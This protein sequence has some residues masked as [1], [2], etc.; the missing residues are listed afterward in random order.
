MSQFALVQ[1][2]VGNKTRK[3]NDVWV[4]ITEVPPQSTLSSYSAQCCPRPVCFAATSADM[5]QVL[6]S[7]SYCWNVEYFRKEYFGVV[8]NTRIKWTSWPAATPQD[9][10][11][12][13][14]FVQTLG[15]KG[16]STSHGTTMPNSSVSYARVNWF[17]DQQDCPHRLLLHVFLMGH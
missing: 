6:F 3:I 7:A 16:T 13:V 12:K 14:F 8:R 15:T 4:G 1:N 17:Q 11:V 9:E 2:N 10:E 5:C